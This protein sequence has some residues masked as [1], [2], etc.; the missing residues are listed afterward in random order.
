[1]N[2]FGNTPVIIVVLLGHINTALCLLKE[3][4]AD[5]ITAANNGQTT[6]CKN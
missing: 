6:W 4:G 2:D 1:M 3:Y 5:I